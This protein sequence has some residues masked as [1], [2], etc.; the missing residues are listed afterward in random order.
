MRPIRLAL[1]AFGPYLARQEIDFGSLSD[2]SLFLIHGPTGAGKTTL[3]DAMCFALYGE[4]SGSLTA[5]KQQQERSASQMRT[6]NSPPDV[7]TEVTLDFSLGSKIYRAYRR[8]AHT[9]PKKSGLGTITDPAKGTLWE[10]TA[11]EELDP[12]STPLAA[13][14]EK[15]TE[16]IES[17]LGLKSSQFCQVVLL[18]QGKFRQFLTAGSIERQAVLEALFGAE[19]YRRI[20]KSL[21]EAVEKIASDLEIAQLKRDHLLQMAQAASSEELSTRRELKSRELAR[22]KELLAALKVQEKSANENVL[23]G[24]QHAALIKERDLAA[25]E[26]ETFASTAAGILCE[27]LKA[28]RAA[29]AAKLLDSETELSQRRGEST[30]AT[31]A[32]RECTEALALAQESLARAQAGLV[33]E[34]RRDSLRV[35]TQQN[36]DRLTAMVASVA[37]LQH[38]QRAFEAMEKALVAA[39]KSGNALDTEID[40]CATNVRTLDA[41]L[42]AAR[43]VAATLETLT[44]RHEQARRRF[45]EREKLEKLRG[46]LFAA[47]IA[48]DN[49][50]G[51]LLELEKKIA[52]ARRDKDVLQHAWESGQAAVLA[53]QLKPDHPCPVCGSTKHPLP[54]PAPGNLPTE[55]NVK[56][57]REEVDRLESTRLAALNESA[58]AR[59]AC[60]T[61]QNESRVREDSLGDAAVLTLAILL[62][63]RDAIEKNVSDTERAA[64][65]VPLSERKCALAKAEFDASLEKKKSLDEDLRKLESERESLAAV[66]AER[67]RGVPVEY[68]TPLALEHARSAAG[69]TLQKLT[70]AREK[71]MSDCEK[72]VA[73]VERLAATQ[74]ERS[75]FLTESNEKSQAAE[76]H[77]ILKLDAAGFKNTGDF[78]AAK[79]S[80]S[81]LRDLEQNLREF[82]GKQDAANERLKRAN[83]AADGLRAPDLPAL[84]AALAALTN[85][86]AEA[87][88]EQANV[89]RECDDI[90]RYV[91]QLKGAIETWDRLQQ[92]HAP[93]A[94]LAQAA[95]GQNPFKLTFQRFVMGAMLD[96]VLAAASQRLRLMSRGRFHLQRAQLESGQR[97]AGGLDM[98]V[99]DFFTGTARPVSTLSGGESFLAS[100]A[101][102][103]GTADVVQSYSGG[104]HLDAVFIDEGFGSLDAEALELALQALIDLQQTGRM[105]G[106]ISHVPELRERIG[107]R[108]EI[109]ITRAGSEAHVH[110]QFTL[111]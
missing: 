59:T 64:K 62:K 12:L 91:T 51:L 54:A 67:Q 21:K 88:E 73:E 7:H 10:L 44:L 60:S 84:Q 4:T 106:I 85:S 96:D 78:T 36:V 16:R 28:E 32:V 101:L 105:V 13:G 46:E 71:A 99:Y 83:S 95:N 109:S 2:R 14:A 24:H 31:Q 55:S 56:A 69:E 8:A 25:A 15:V 30:A 35:E 65:E 77:F 49:H 97:S 58:Q 107:A 26:C 74:I 42:N 37:E 39:R 47:V 81:A 57:R 20:E 63:E 111:G 48:A 19:L 108:L 18:P 9:R 33:E 102:A 72:S 100:L 29:A 41:A 94:T 34:K 45:E 82:E 11:K 3:L 40:A 90:E 86:I 89:S 6:D 5:A 17:L 50:S 27:R 76:R 87:L 104:V 93:L 38:S 79:M 23:R 1:Q 103:L 52:D 53:Q 61:L 110:K 43:A 92:R 80:S 66:L 68:R 22:V 98:D 75:R 70:R